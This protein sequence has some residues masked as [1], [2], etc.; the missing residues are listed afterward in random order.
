MKKIQSL[1]VSA[2]LA[3][4]MAAPVLAAQTDPEVILYRFPGVRDDGSAA[5]A[6]I[7]TLFHCTN[8]SGALETIRFVTR[9]PDGSLRQNSETSI[10]HLGTVTAG[11]HATSVYFEDLVL[12]T[13]QVAQGT[14]A[15]AATS[16]SIICTAMTVDA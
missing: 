9:R 1:L 16:T 13:G 11:T 4:G 10:P 8:F 7:A 14:T 6:G 2:A 5:N 15:I 12:A 3:I